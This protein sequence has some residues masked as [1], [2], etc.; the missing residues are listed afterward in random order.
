MVRPPTHTLVMVSPLHKAGECI[1]AN[2][3]H[4]LF[5]VRLT[6]DTFPRFAD[7]FLALPLPL[8]LLSFF[9]H[10]PSFE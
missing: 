4:R 8:T 9:F 5:V 6:H 10:E 1:M 3:V 2:A 7:S